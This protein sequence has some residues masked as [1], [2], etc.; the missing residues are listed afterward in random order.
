MLTTSGTKII[1][2]YLRPVEGKDNS[3]VKEYYSKLESAYDS[4]SLNGIAFLLVVFKTRIGAVSLHRW[5]T[6]EWNPR[7]AFQKLC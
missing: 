6:G 7:N 1:V 4:L 5:T 2:K 3:I